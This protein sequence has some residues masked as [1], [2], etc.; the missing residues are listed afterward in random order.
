MATHLHSPSHIHSLHWLSLH[1]CLLGCLMWHLMPFMMPFV[2]EVPCTFPLLMTRVGDAGSRATS[3]SVG[4][5]PNW[6]RLYT[7]ERSGW[8]LQLFASFGPVSVWKTS[9]TI[10]KA[11]AGTVWPWYTTSRQNLPL[12]FHYRIDA[13]WPLTLP[14]ML[15]HTCPGFCQCML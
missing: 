9:F 2:P 15:D 10:G 4:W 11:P 7:A 13:I 6:W 12:L 5:C 1:R 14:L 8:S 3:W